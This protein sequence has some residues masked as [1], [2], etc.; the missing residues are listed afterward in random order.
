MLNNNNRERTLL[1]IYRLNINY[2]VNYYFKTNNLYFNNFKW[3]LLPVKDSL[4]K[5]I[6]SL[7]KLLNRRCSKLRPRKFKRNKLRS[8]CR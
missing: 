2:E 1:N 5:K 4:N 6:N 8:L 7:Y 3:V